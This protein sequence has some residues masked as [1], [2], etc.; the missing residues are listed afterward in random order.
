MLFNT[1]DTYTISNWLDCQIMIE[2]SKNLYFNL[3]FK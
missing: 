2:K 3:R 1:S